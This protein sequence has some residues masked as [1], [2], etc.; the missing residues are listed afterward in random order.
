[1][2]TPAIPVYQSEPEE[3]RK[4]VDT[5]A[6]PANQSEPEEI[7]ETVETLP[8]QLI[9]VNQRRSQTVDTLP[10]QLLRANQR[11]SQRP[12]RP[13]HC[14]YSERTRGGPRD[15]ADPCHSS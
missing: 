15:R 14:S 3:V 9:R 2:E 13:C 6:I 10:F 5:A 11:R 1:M 8:L 7:P 4:T 12:L